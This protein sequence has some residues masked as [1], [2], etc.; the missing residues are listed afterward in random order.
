M[1]DGFEMDSTWILFHIQKLNLNFALKGVWGDRAYSQL[2]IKEGI[3]CSTR[4]EPQGM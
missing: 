4:D 3:G 1:A 2:V